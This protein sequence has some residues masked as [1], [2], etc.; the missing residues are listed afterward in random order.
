M[1]D[2]RTKGKHKPQFSNSVLNKIKL[3]SEI[4]KYLVTEHLK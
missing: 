4:E 3:K 2:F 1:D